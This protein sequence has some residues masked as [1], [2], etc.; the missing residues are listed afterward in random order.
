M[1]RNCER[2]AQV[3]ILL[4]GQKRQ[5]KVSKM[6]HSFFR[7]FA[8]ELLVIARYTRIMKIIIAGLPSE[9]KT[10]IAQF[11]TRA[12]RDAGFAV[13]H[14]DIDG[15]LVEDEESGMQRRRLETVGKRLGPITVATYSTNHEGFTVTFPGS[16]G[17]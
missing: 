14:A 16:D 5:A 7:R 11:I 10:T 8:S 4:A 17:G 2:E 13:H 6:V 12:L 3:R 15:G 9:G 1:R